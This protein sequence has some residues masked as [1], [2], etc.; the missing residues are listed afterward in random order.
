M[1]IGGFKDP[2][3]RKEII[4]AVQKIFS[5]T[6]ALGEEPNPTKAIRELRNIKK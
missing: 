1:E 6:Y 4:E 2:V 3:D 5:E